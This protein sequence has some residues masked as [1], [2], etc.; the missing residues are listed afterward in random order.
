M[1]GPIFTPPTMTHLPRYNMT[2]SAILG[3]MVAII[4]Y[5]ILLLGTLAS[6]L[7]YSAEYYAK[8]IREKGTLY[9][10]QQPTY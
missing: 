9:Q 3:L 1:M 6:F 5:G 8:E 10:V 4:G 7:K 2:G